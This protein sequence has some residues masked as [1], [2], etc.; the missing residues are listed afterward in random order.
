MDDEKLFYE[1]PVTQ[2]IEMNME[3]SILDASLSGTRRDYGTANEDT[4]N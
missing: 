2:V 4:W 1:C 3:A